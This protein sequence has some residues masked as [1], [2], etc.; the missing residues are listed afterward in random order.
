MDE[1]LQKI[2]KYLRLG[3]LLANWDSLLA[4]ARQGKFSHERLL[5]HVLQA[6]YC[7]KG[8][9]ARL[10]RRKR[11]HIPEP[12]ELETTRFKLALKAFELVAEAKE[13]IRE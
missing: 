6:E 2:L 1:E 9:N 7:G 4:E 11:A 5:R 8:E 3:G 13:L 10:L 12:W